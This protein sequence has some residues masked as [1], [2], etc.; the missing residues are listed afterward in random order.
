MHGPFSMPK[1]SVIV[2]NYNH[3][4]YLTWRIDSVLNQ[5]YRD[6]ELIIL[7]D[8]S[9]DSSREVIERY[10]NLTNV[11]FHPNSRNSGSVFAQWE[12][13]IQLSIG[14]YIWIAE[15]DDWAADS[16]L[17]K[18]VRVLDECPNVGVVYTQSWLADTQFKVTG[19]AICWT[20]DLDLTL[21]KTDFSMAG[22]E[23]IR[24]FLLRK[25]AIPN[26]SAVV[27]R[28]TS[29]EKALPIEKN[30]KLCGDWHHWIRILATTDVAYL[31]ERLNFWRL[32]SSNARSEAPGVL[33]WIEGERILAEGCRL[34]G[35]PES[36]QDKVLLTFLRQCWQ[37]QR[38]YIAKQKAASPSSP[39]K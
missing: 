12:K 15:S 13:G 30:F 7:D 16:F 22:A 14:D 31:S 33:E 37:W 10:R 34:V 21:W 24:R 5:S 18:T 28:R 39:S 6:F 27:M 2:P 4:R 8:C 23:F 26:A 19:D 1:V 35:L 32:D 20:E 36:A 9:T 29:L 3:S 38:D 17:E 11:R 25:N